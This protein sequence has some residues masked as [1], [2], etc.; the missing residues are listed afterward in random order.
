MVGGRPGSNTRDGSQ[1]KTHVS[2][3]TTK[4][5]T[6]NVSFGPQGIGFVLPHAFFCLTPGLGFCLAPELCFCLAPG[7]SLHAQDLTDLP[8]NV[9]GRSFCFTQNLLFIFFVIKL[10]AGRLPE[11][12]LPKAFTQVL[13]APESGYGS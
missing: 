12:R 9:N 1:T 11:L 3:T 5:T 4:A 2:I 13:G 8:D 7:M 6:T 10:Y